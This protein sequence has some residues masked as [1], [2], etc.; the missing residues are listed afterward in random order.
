MP[1]RI[2]ESNLL[3]LIIVSV[4]TVLGWIA[5][6]VSLDGEVSSGL[7]CRLRPDH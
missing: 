5:I 1:L 7:C 2:V 3:K 4:V 6:V